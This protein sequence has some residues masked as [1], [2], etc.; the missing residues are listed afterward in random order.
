MN[1]AWSAQTGGG[2]D[3]KRKFRET[4]HKA[5]RALRQERLNEKK[6]N[7]E[8]RRSIEDRLSKILF[9]QPAAADMLL[10]TFSSAL[11]CYRRAS[12]CEP[13]PDAF[14]QSEHERNYADAVW[15]R[16]R[17]QNYFF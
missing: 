7:E 1:T 13:F 17:P 2:V 3:K 8:P 15:D 10:S 11:F 4:N 14:V 9:E 16:S 12:V 5:H 6:A